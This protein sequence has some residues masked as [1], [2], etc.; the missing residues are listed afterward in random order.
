MGKNNMMFKWKDY[1]NYSLLLLKNDNTLI[2]KL[3]YKTKKL[4]ISEFEYYVKLEY[5]N[6]EDGKKKA[7]EYYINF[8]EALS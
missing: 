7:E 2:A 6:L 3:D 4:L 1:K 5:D 8:T